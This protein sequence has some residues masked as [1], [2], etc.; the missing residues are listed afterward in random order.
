MSAHKQSTGKLNNSNV[1]GSKVNTGARGA[2]QNSLNEL[3]SDMP[4]RGVPLF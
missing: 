2:K 4:E 1:I 3:R